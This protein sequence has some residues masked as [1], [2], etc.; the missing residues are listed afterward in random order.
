MFA[1]KQLKPLFLA[2]PGIGECTLLPMNLVPAEFRS[3][4]R[5]LATAQGLDLTEFGVLSLLEIQPIFKALSFVLSERGVDA[6]ESISVMLSGSHLAYPKIDIDLINQQ[7][8]QCVTTMQFYFW[9]D[10]FLENGEILLPGQIDMQLDEI[11]VNECIENETKD[12]TYCLFLGTADCFLPA[13]P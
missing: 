3:Y 2:V 10:A 7:M 8:E 11:P 9:N 4:E 1:A 5:M 6:H 12:M 13:N